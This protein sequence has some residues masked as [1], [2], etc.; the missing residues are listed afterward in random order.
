VKL[1][2]VTECAELLDLS[3]QRV[4]QLIAEG[5]LPAQKIGSVW[6]VAAEDARAFKRLPRGKAGAPRGLN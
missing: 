4:L 3:R 1:M 6:I 5:R 2:T